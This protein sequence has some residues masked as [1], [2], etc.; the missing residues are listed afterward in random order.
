[1]KDETIFKI[2]KNLKTRPLEFNE[3]NYNKETL[4]YLTGEVSMTVITIV[5]L[6]AVLG[7]GMFL[8]GSKDSVGRKWIENTFNNITNKGDNAMDNMG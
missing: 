8:F 4:G 7:I 3:D 2:L 1:M 6:V 5:L